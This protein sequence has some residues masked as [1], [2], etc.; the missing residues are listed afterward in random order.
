MAAV[1]AALQAQLAG[2]R[3]VPEML[4]FGRRFRSRALAPPYRL[5]SWGSGAGPARC[6]LDATFDHSPSTVQQ[7]CCRMAAF[8]RRRALVC[9]RVIG[10]SP[11][12]GRRL[13]HQCIRTPRERAEPCRTNRHSPPG[14]RSRRRAHHRAQT[15]RGMPRAGSPIPQARARAP[16]SHVDKAARSPPPTPWTVRK[17][18]A[19]P[20]P[21][22]GIP[23]SIKD[24]FDVRGQVTRAGSLALADSRAG[25]SRRAG[26]GAAAPA[27]FVVIG[28]TNMTEFAYSG[29]GINPHYGTPREPLGPRRSA[30]S[31]AAPPRARRSRSPT[32]WRWRARHR[33][34]RLLPDP[35][36][37]LRH[38]RLQADRSAACRSTAACRSRSRSTARA[39]GAQRRLLRGARR[40]AGG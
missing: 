37:A 2:L 9:Q 11:R 36:R 20:S 21:Y 26:G 13:K 3:A 22:A 29:I 15:G 35:G 10:D 25:R 4:G 19:A 14:R 5:F 8:L 12:H 31:P 24:L 27:G 7:R 17:A 28:R 33:H 1:V 30:A 40:R 34:R 32:A 39:A 16:S 6:D 23:I 18:N 38:R